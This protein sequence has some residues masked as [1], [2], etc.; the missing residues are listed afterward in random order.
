MTSVDDISELKLVALIVDHGDRKAMEKLYRMHVGALAAL[1]SRYVVDADVVNDILQE[2]FLKIFS[3]L[4]GFT[5]RGAGSLRAWM[6]RIV[7]N[8]SLKHLSHVSRFDSLP[9]DDRLVE[10]MAV[11]QSSPDVMSIP[12]DVIQ[13]AIM[14]LPV[15][16]R[17]ILNL[18]LFENMSHKE[19]A[20]MLNIKENSSASQ[21]SRAKALLAKKLND[22]KSRNYV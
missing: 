22:Y 21:Y 9:D 2:S 18:Y 17:T 10:D 14:S 20:R 15:G 16:Y 3:S 12:L 7:I 4:P 19:I 6:S 13:S 5:H 8:E 11:D 1:C